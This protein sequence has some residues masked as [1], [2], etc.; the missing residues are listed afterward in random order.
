MC[1]IG[2]TLGKFQSLSSIDEFQFVWTD[3][4]VRGTQCSAAITI[5]DAPFRCYCNCTERTFCLF[6]KLLFVC[7]AS[8][9]CGCHYRIHLLIDQY[10]GFCDGDRR[11]LFDIKIDGETLSN[12]CL[13]DD[14]RDFEVGSNDSM[15]STKRVETHSDREHEWKWGVGAV[16]GY[17][18]EESGDRMCTDWQH[19]EQHERSKGN[20][21]N[22]PIR[23][24]MYSG[25]SHQGI[26][27]PRFLG[28]RIWFRSGVRVCG[29]QMTP[30]VCRWPVAY[31][32]VHPLHLEVHEIESICISIHYPQC[33]ITFTISYICTLYVFLVRTIAGHVRVSL[34]FY[35]EYC[36]NCCCCPLFEY[37]RGDSTWKRITSS[38]LPIIVWA[39][40]SWT[41][42]LRWMRS[43]CPIPKCMEMDLQIME[44]ETIQIATAMEQ[45]S[46]SSPQIGNGGT[47]LW[48]TKGSCDYS[49]GKWG[50]HLFDRNSFQKSS[51]MMTD[52]WGLSL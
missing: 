32:W 20:N 40:T 25:G 45:L 44:I 50:L 8:V 42:M 18:D 31:S 29:M 30:I 12:H 16:W 2:N 11:L 5:H 51:W 46:G 47:H 28:E 27:I 13:V 24:A 23:R 1:R 37:L 22:L 3:H 48:I 49:M 38:K 10:F 15:R 33:F 39:R 26:W 43:N 7:W 52:S 19:G 21:H 41:F 35:T 17:D 4:I 9:I 34:H 14:E 6:S 36:C